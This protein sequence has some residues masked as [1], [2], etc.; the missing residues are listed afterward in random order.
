MPSVGPI[1]PSPIETGKPPGTFP[2]VLRLRSINLTANKR[3]LGL[4]AMRRDLFVNES[5]LYVNEGESLP[6]NVTFEQAGAITGT[7]TLKAYKG[8]TDVSTTVLTPTNGNCTVSGNVVSLPTFAAF[9]GGERYV[10]EL[11]AVVDGITLVK[12][13]VIIVRAKGSE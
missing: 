3:V 1:P 7:P 5:P 12:V 9:T 13:A 4:F 6:Y 2:R 11:T 8:G 10:F